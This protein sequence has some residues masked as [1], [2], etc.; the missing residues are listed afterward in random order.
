M[1]NKEAGSVSVSRNRRSSKL[2]MKL[3]YEIHATFDQRWFRN[4]LYLGSSMPCEHF[5]FSPA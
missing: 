1:A 2:K 5:P 4:P 3:C